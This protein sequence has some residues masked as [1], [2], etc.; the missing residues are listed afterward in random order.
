MCADY[1]TMNCV[2]DM[3]KVL[4]SVLCEG[5]RCYPIPSHPIYL[6]TYSYNSPHLPM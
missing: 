5:H 1:L 6:L 2:R 4:V 3:I